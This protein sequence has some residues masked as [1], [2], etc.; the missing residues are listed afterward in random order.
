LKEKN[1]GG[2]KKE[3]KKISKENEVRQVGTG[4]PRHGEKEKHGDEEE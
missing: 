1:T 3:H 2:G 4:I